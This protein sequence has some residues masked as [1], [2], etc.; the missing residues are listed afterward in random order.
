MKNKTRNWHAVRDI[1]NMKALLCDIEQHRFVIR[2]HAWRQSGNWGQVFYEA[3]MM[4]CA[5]RALEESLTECWEGIY[6]M[7]TYDGLPRGDEH[8]RT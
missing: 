7:A 3:E 1:E 8:E 6:R 5:V 4:R 2:T